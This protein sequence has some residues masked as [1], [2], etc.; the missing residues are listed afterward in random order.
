[1]LYRSPRSSMG[2]Q[3]SAPGPSNR[4]SQSV[5]LFFFHS[6]LFPRS[7]FRVIKHTRSLNLV[8]FFLD[9]TSWTHVFISVQYFK[10]YICSETRNY[11]ARRSAWAGI[12][13]YSFLNISI[14]TR[15][16]E[17]I[18]VYNVVSIEICRI[19]DSFICDL[20]CIIIVTGIVNATPKYLTFDA[21]CL[22]RCT[23]YY[24]G[25]IYSL[26]GTFY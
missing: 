17:T 14:L 6:Y 3:R 8:L 18:C 25:I 1:M 20:Y 13:E 16:D 23:F 7:V 10:Y 22:V 2:K 4:M 12:F 9:K 5:L 15:T 26:Y 24:I 11:H 19:R 21:I